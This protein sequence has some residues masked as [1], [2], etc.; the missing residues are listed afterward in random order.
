MKAVLGPR[1]IVDC[2]EGEPSL[3]DK[4]SETGYVTTHLSMQFFE[5]ERK[6]SQSGLLVEIEGL[7]RIG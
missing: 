7:S 3:S 1:S 5:P 4:V 6:S 2:R